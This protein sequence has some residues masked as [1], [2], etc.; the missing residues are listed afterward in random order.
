MTLEMS[1]SAEKDVIICNKRGLHAR[2]AARFVE[3]ARQFSS[4]ISV[5]KDNLQVSGRSIMGLLLL[6]AATGEAIRISAEG[7][8]CEA[9]L[10]ALETLVCDRFREKD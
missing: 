2:A 4:K 7:E 5:S 8:D 1:A 6:A 3:K 9:A 10:Q